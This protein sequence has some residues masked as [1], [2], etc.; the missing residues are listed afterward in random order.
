MRRFWVLLVAALLV[1]GV[2][3]PAVSD[4]RAQNQRTV[5]GPCIDGF[6][7]RGTA[8][9]LRGQAILSGCRE[10]E[11]P[12]PISLSCQSGTATIE[13]EVDALLSGRNGRFSF[14]LAVK[15][16]RWLGTF[17][18]SGKANTTGMYETL[19]A[20]IPVDHPVI[21]LL[22]SGRQVM[23][24]AP[25]DARYHHLNGSR[26]AIATMLRGCSLG[27]NPRASASPPGPAATAGRRSEL[28]VLFN[29]PAGPGPLWVDRNAATQL[30]GDCR[31]DWARFVRKWGAAAFAVSPSGACGARFED[32]NLAA[33]K[34]GALNECRKWSNG[35]T[36][37]LIGTRPRVDWEIYGTC[38]Q[39]YVS[40]KQRSAGSAFAA[41]SIAQKG[42]CGWVDTAASLD[43]ARRIAQKSCFDAQDGL[44]SECRTVAVRR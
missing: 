13:I 21:G 33:A 31:A 26:E 9:S 32:F 44:R 27:G 10:S 18:F 43:A 34:D 7:W 38:E 40:W 36:C 23:I 1:S 12:E 39:Q 30:T 16:D 14:A 37:R 41:F 2:L 29:T 11:Q 28:V 4:A 5:N 17:E 42:A 3:G 24:D 25:G 8:G 15:R 6:S 35:Q 20:S 19:T 22:Q